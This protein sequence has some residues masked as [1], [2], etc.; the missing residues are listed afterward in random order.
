MSWR[1]FY[2]LPGQIILK[3]WIGLSVIKL[4]SQIYVRSHNYDYGLLE[5]EF[6]I[7]ITKFQYRTYLVSH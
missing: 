1:P 4:F 6:K 7:E 2:S 5:F 3:Y